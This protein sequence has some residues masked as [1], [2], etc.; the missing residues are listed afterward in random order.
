M[1]AL[2][3]QVMSK[4]LRRGQMFTEA[5]ERKAAEPDIFMKI[6]GP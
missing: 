3:H 2:D 1:P 5:A 4:T 6:Q